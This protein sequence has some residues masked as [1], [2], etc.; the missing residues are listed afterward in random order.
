MQS[1]CRWHAGEVHSVRPCS[2]VQACGRHAG[3][4]AR[5]AACRWHGGEAQPGAGV[6]NTLRDPTM[7]N[8][9][10]VLDFLESCWRLSWG[11]KA[12]QHHQQVRRQD[13]RNLPGPKWQR[14]INGLALIFW[15]ACVDFLVSFARLISEFKSS[16]HRNKSI[17]R[18][19]Q[20]PQKNSDLIVFQNSC[21]RLIAD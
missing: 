13:A 19:H 7:Q 14:K 16:Q 4:E 15:L 11:L 3:A 6:H 5:H 21:G 18:I 1:A 20:T 17:D 8:Q 12:S 2:S 9:L 10:N